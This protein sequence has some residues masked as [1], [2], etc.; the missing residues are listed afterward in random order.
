MRDGEIRQI[1]IPVD[2][3]SNPDHLDVAEFMGFRNLV[4]GRVLSIAGGTA[5]IA[6][7][8]ATLTGRTRGG[9][10]AGSGGHIAIRPEDLT[11]RPAGG[12]GLKATILSLEFRG[13]EF[14][15]FARMEDGT[16][17]SFLAHESLEP[18]IEVT[19]GADP[20]RALVF[21]GGAA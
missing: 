7:G 1:G 18:G 19:L 9:V 15:G 4:P 16:D 8:S 10:S 3:F 20:D 14:V 11:P 5:K 13:H 21:G 17:L 12:E 2:L 6:I